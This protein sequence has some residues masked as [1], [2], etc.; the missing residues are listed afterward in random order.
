VLHYVRWVA[1]G[2]AEFD[3]R[4]NVKPSTKV[5]VPTTAPV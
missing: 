3:K 5:L 2:F 4:G 1:P